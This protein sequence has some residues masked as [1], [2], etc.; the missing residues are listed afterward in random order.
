MIDDIRAGIIGNVY[1]AKCWYANRRGPVYLKDGTVPSWL[2]WELWQGPVQRRPYREGLVHYNWHWTRHYGTGEGPM[3]ASHEVDIARWGLGVEFPARVQSMGGRYAYK[4]DLEWPDTQI[5][6]VEFPE[7]K[8]IVWEGR[9]CNGYRVDGADRGTTFY[10]ENGTIVNPGGNSYTVYDKADKI[11][12]QFDDEIDSKETTNTVS[13]GV[14]LD[15]M[16]VANF[17]DCIRSGKTPNCT[18]ETG[19]RSTLLTQL[20]NIA[21]L[22]RQT[23]EIDTANGHILNNAEAQ[24][25]WSKEYEKGWEPQQYI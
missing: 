23:L 25:Y 15:K 20:A 7:N 22:T 13:A 1:M 4:D 16:H 3:N 5:F 11:I 24:K 12:K 18:S 14:N 9:S 8:L 6:T 17:L 2:D 21:L 10:G 19:H